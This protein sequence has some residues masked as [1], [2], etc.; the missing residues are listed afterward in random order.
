MEFYGFEIKKTCNYCRHVSP[1]L[2]RLGRTAKT[3]KG[4]DK[5]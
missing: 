3:D 2:N 4:T 5:N 1:L